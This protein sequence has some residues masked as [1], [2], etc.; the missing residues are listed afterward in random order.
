MQGNKLRNFQMML[1]GTQHPDHCQWLFYFCSLCGLASVPLLAFPLLVLF[2]LCWFMQATGWGWWGIRP[3]ACASLETTAEDW[4]LSFLWLIFAW[5]PRCGT[6]GWEAGR[7]A[8]CLVQR[9]LMSVAGVVAIDDW[10]LLVCL[11]HNLTRPTC[12]STTASASSLLFTT[13]NTQLCPPFNLSSSDHSSNS[14]PV[15]AGGHWR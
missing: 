1:F 3:E 2:F 13:L 15:F 12:A 9:A 6:F 10:L 4:L 11:P 14:N 8:S 5:E 7:N